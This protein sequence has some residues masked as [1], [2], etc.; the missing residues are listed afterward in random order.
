MRPRIWTF[1]SIAII[2]LGVSGCRKQPEAT[3]V[4]PLLAAYDTELDW[5]DSQRVIPL[6]YQQAQG[7]RVFY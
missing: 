3:K 5:N 6:N 1:A 4:D 2:A 7:K